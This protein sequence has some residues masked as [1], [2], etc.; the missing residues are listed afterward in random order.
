MSTCSN[1]QQLDLLDIAKRHYSKNNPFLSSRTSFS[2]CCEDRTSTLS[3]FREVNAQRKAAF[4]QKMQKYRASS[5]T[6]SLYNHN[7]SSNNNLNLSIEN[8]E[9]STRNEPIK[10]STSSTENIISKNTTYFF[11]KMSMV[12]LVFSVKQ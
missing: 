6:N 8:I 10:E 4:E 1:K 9:N 7:N 2:S 3:H 5:E 11:K 12:E